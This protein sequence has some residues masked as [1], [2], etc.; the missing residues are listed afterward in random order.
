MAVRYSIRLNLKCT[1]RLA[2]CM[3][4]LWALEGTR[5]ADC[6]LMFYTLRETERETFHR[7]HIYKGVTFCKL[8]AGY[9]LT[10]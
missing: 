10:P 8:K 3:K 9:L 7:L 5:Y 1:D 6:D 2:I 4:S